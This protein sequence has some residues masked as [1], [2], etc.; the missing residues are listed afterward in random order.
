MLRHDNFSFV[1][2]IKHQT[3]S[4]TND[5]LSFTYR[6]CGSA[7]FSLCALSGVEVPTSTLKSALL[8]FVE[9]FINF[10]KHYK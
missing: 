2:L 3:I 9:I 8:Y 7:G 6:I 5:L 10:N 1:L 4:G